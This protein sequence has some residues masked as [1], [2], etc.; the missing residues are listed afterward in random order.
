MGI[1]AA[2]KNQIWSV[3]PAQPIARISTMDEVLA[4][5]VADRRFNLLLFGSFAAVALLLAGV[6][7]YGVISYTVSQR[8]HEIGVRMALGAKTTDVLRLFLAQGLRLA[9]T[10]VVIGVAGALALTRLMK[11]LLFGVGATDPLTFAGVALLLTLVALLACF[12]PARRAARIEP[13]RALRHE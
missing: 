5:S 11:E 13:L 10:G 12:I 2:V 9:V 1:V 8:T 4:R 7:V 3:D 6:G